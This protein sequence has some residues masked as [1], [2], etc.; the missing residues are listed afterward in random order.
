MFIFLYTVFRNSSIS[1]EHVFCVALH[2]TIGQIELFKKQNNKYIT[3]VELSAIDSL[4]SQ[5]ALYNMIESIA[6][7][8]LNSG[9]IKDIQG[10]NFE[11][12]VAAALS[13][14]DNLCKWKTNNKL[15]T[16]MYYN[17]FETV[18]S[19]LNLDSSTI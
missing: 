12:I 13:K 11:S 14:T 19:Y 7:T 6:T 4:I 15:S 5:N 8:S 18:V 10:R 9:Q 17:I 16:G 2:F 3:K 1:D